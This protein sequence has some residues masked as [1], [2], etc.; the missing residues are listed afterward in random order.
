MTFVEK[1]DNILKHSKLKIATPSALEKYIEASQSSIVR[2][3][4]ENKAPGKDIQKRIIEKLGVNQAWWDTGQ[5]EIFTAES[6]APKA[7][8]ASEIEDPAVIKLIETLESTVASKNEEVH[9][10]RQHIDKLTVGLGSIKQ[11]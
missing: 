8:T 11:A 6:E 5:G 3:Y 1:I 10:L 4:R 7:K 2:Y 9:W